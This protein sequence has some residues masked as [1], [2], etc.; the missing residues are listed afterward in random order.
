[1]TV[2]EMGVRTDEVC[3]RS[4]ELEVL[5]PVG[6]LAGEVGGS[7]GSPSWATMPAFWIS[8]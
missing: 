3:R 1:M 2:R 5:V 7:D 8:W 4:A 6:G